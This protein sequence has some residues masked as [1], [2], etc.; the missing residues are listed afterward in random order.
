MSR[1]D[2]TVESEGIAVQAGR[3]VVVHQGMSPQ[4]M[5]EI[6]VAIAKQLSIYHDEARQIA[7]QRFASF[8]EELLKRFT[9]PKQANPDAFRDPDFQY[10]IGDAQEA[11]ARS[12]DEAVRDT[13]IDIIARRSLEKTRNRLAITLNDAATKAANLTENEFAA[14]SLSYLVRYT[15]NNGVNTF[16]A[17]CD[18]LKSHLQPFVRNIS[19]EQSSFWHMQAQACGSIEIGEVDLVVALRGRYTGV[20]GDGFARQQLED[21][22]PD[23]KKTALDN[24]IIPCINDASKLQPSAIRFDV[25]KEIALPSSGLSEQ[26]LQNVWN[27]FE[28]TIPDLVKRTT[29]AVPELAELFNIW[30]A[31]PLKQFSLT[32]VG[33]AIGHANAARVIGL[34]ASLDVWI[35]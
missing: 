7:D 8:Q 4:Q 1:Q 22:L 25:W 21:H 14:L 24:F 29:D 26:E 3:D 31:T 13:L 11:F 19:P 35:K 33:I 23:G 28:S 10:L 5:S 17:F 18:Y 32:S 9:D 20:L 15:V 16:S 34:T 12:G 2:Q 30:K 27:L 6:M